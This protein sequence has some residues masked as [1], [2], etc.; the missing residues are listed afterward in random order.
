MHD[1]TRALYPTDLLCLGTSLI[2]SALSFLNAGKRWVDAAGLRLDREVLVGL[3]FLLLVPGLLLLFRLLNPVRSRLVQF[4]RLFYPQ[5]L[6]FVFFQ[7]CILLS[8]LLY[9]GRSLDAVFARADAWLFGFQPALEFHRAL[10]AHP[11]VVEA[12]FFGYFFYFILITAGWWLLFLQRRYREAARALAITSACFCLMFL[13]F[14]LFPVQGP[15]YYFPQL[16]EAWYG[17]FQGYLATWFMRGTF[18][19][20]N[21]AGAAFP[22]SH[23]AIATLAFSLN[24]R[25]NRRLAWVF[26]PL[27]L[28]LFASTV[29]LYAHYAVDVLA[30][31]AVGLCFAFG[32][33]RL[34]DRAGPLHGRLERPLAA[35]FRLRP[36]ALSGNEPARL[37]RRLE[38]GSPSP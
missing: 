5:A 24:W 33:P 29:Y 19:R 25:C 1:D 30:G 17:N 28:L 14:S 9:G 20:L 10:P 8:Q 31:L 26:L 7:E 3:L 13:F 21:L 27:T 16:R 34:L 35:A 12:F 18:D 6:Y 22:S 11:A 4:F 38:G 15:K 23:V 2:F 32:M 36:I 37:L